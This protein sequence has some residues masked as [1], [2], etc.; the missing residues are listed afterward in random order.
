MLKKGIKN[1]NCPGKKMKKA[2]LIWAIQ[3]AE[4]YDTCHEQKEEK[5][6]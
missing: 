3:K 4:G 2:D 6:I 5:K 1:R